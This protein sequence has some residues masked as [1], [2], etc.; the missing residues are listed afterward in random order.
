MPFHEYANYDALG[1]AELI[2]SRQIS[3]AE[4]LEEAIRRRDAVNPQINAVVYNMDAI[5]RAQVNQALPDAPFAGVPFLLKDFCAAYAGV[6]LTNG[7]RAFKNYVPDYDCELVKRLKASGVIT[8]GKTNTPEFAIVGAT[9]PALHGITR[10]PWNPERTA[11]GSSGGSGAAVAAGIVPM[12]SGG[13]GGGSLRIPAACGGLVGFKASRGRVPHGPM[14]GDPWYGQVQDGVISRSVRDSAAMLDAIRGADL[15]APYAEPALPGSLLDACQKAPGKLRIAFSERPLMREGALHPEALKG[16]QRTVTLLQEL[17]HEL[18]EAHPPLHY[19][20]LVEGYLLRIAASVGGEIIATEN[21]LGRKLHYEDLEPETWMLAQLGRSYSAARFDIAHRR[22]Y[23]ESRRFEAF[24]QEY[25]VFLTPTLSGP[26]V[27]H[28]YF[29]SRG[30]ENWLAPI[31]SRLP[32][33]P[34]AANKSTLQRLA[35]QAFDWV[36]ATM[37]FNITGNPS[38]SL[39]LHWSDD[40]LP[41]GMMFTA[42]FGRDDQLFTLAGQLEQAQPWWHQ[43]PPLFSE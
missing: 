39:P 37:A 27:E 40:R 38:V 28:G 32:L 12:A 15:G 7:S 23:T 21:L 3:A 30:L 31:A 4:V 17:G 10:N 43:R 14:H 13:D 6:P 1:L 25:D 20:H 19:E 11:G 29:K 33:G 16:L 8:F 22:L 2:K 42:P 5:A 26:P 18:V 24:I 34:L 35:D 36:C 9:E 41:V